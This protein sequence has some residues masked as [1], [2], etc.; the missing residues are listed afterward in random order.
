[1]QVPWLMYTDIHAVVAAAVA[2]VTL[3][4]D[5]IRLAQVIRQ[6]V[7]IIIVTTRLGPVVVHQI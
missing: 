6:T 4:K 5:V 2:I 7:V 3:V 1:M